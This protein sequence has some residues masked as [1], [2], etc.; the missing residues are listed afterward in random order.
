MPGSVIMMLSPNVANKIA[1]GEVVERP[2][3]VVKELMENSVDA[4]ATR[5]EVSVT[6][7]GRKLIAVSDNG[8]GM[9]RDD[10]MM[11][12]ERHA[13][14]K[15][16]EVEDIEKVGTLGF[17]GEALASISS[18]SRFFLRTRTKND[19]TGTEVEISGGRLIDVRDCGCP[20]GTEILVRDLFFN[21][22]AR[23]SFLKTFQTEQAHIKN[24][25]Y[26]HAA[27][28]PR[29]A[30]VL[31]CDG[32]EAY[33]LPAAESLADRLR[34]LAGEEDLAH[35]IPFDGSCGRVR[36]HGFAGEPGWT[37]PDRAGQYIF[38]NGRPAAA[39]SVY[40]ALN[41][42]Y[43][44]LGEG[45]RPQI[46]LYIETPPDFVDVNVHP[47]KREVRFRN[48]SEIRQAVTEVIRGALRGGPVGMREAEPPPVTDWN[49]ERAGACVQPSGTPPPVPPP[50]VFSQPELPSGD[51]LYG[52][53]LSGGGFA[54]ERGEEAKFSVAGDGLP[55]TAPWSEFRIIGRLS[56]GYV[57]METSG[58]YTVL[59]PAAARERVVY[60]RLLA[61]SAGGE[62]HSQG[63]LMPQTVELKPAD[64]AA[65]LKVLPQLKGM[66]FGIEPFGNGVFSVDAV[67][68]AVSGTDCREILAETAAAVINAGTRH[69]DLWRERAAAMAA[70]KAASRGAYR[71]S[72]GE[73][74]MVVEAL[75]RCDMPYARPS[76]GPTMIFTS[77]RDLDRRFGRSGGG[78]PGGRVET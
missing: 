9:N 73:L 35:M 33:R 13:T 7:G 3:A 55:A 14:S 21:V 72:D 44:G 70:G 67:P 10:A 53:V 61:E 40:A 1:A 5:V 54:G 45:R 41:E 32:E 20:P 25:V 77:N 19:E 51:V 66:G 50:V 18:V 38:V 59:D 62:P 23:R 15:I 12:P 46:Y 30:F 39:P 11:A 64:A 27:A 31:K 49:T 56:S 28:Y 26:V 68:D 8:C 16:R 4:G 47:A 74:R 76:G 48:N 24:M 17:R 65:V 63:L 71:L 42:A 22:P 52:D 57:L 60:E 58:G 2:A 6:A 43:P 37:R 34:D 69:R 36:V 75:A 78:A 29:I